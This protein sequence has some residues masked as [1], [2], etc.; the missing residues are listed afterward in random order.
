MTGTETLRALV[1]EDE[2]LGRAKLRELLEPV[3][4]LRWVGEA[5]TV[6]AAQDALARLGPDLV[7][8]DVQLPGGSGLD[9]LR[10]AEPGT[11]VIFT[12]A[13][14]RF[15]VTAFELGALDYLL[16]PFGA[17]RFA[18][19]LERARPLLLSRHGS[20]ADRGRELL[21]PGRLERLFVRDEGRI[22][23]LPVT[24]IERVQ[25]CD[26]VVLV[27]AS[28]RVYRLAVTL[29]ELEER[30]DPRAFVRVHRSHLVNLDQVVSFAPTDDARLL[31]T[32]RSGTTLFASRQRSRE[33]RGLGR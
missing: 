7:F 9:V 12:T 20:A 1:V 19:A 16:K 28:G 10:A 31:V 18:R 21:G 11:G 29:A 25:A 27:H 15:A 5:G 17:E 13:Y 3:P 6:S 23:P 22:V 2:P 33:L 32:L 26:D 14:D 8:L 4:W 30:L 24:D